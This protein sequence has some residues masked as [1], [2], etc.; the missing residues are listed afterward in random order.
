MGLIPF[1]PADRAGLYGDCVE[2]GK[3]VPSLITCMSSAF[4]FVTLFWNIAEI[5]TLHD[6]IDGMGM[7]QAQIMGGH[8]AHRLPGF[9]NS[10][11]KLDINRLQSAGK[12]GKIS[13][14]TG[15]TVRWTN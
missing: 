8:G 12:N 13:P 7:P 3:S 2:K 15:D 9:R 14:R 1:F 4:N 6:Q 10:L 5:F 11:F